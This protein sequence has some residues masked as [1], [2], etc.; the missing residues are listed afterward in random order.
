MCVVCVRV[1][2][3][4]VCVCVLCVVTIN[5]AGGCVYSMGDGFV[6]V[7][8]IQIEPHHVGLMINIWLDDYMWRGTLDEIEYTSG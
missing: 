4:S 1:C 6:L 2:V 5:A 3:C 7:G 8:G